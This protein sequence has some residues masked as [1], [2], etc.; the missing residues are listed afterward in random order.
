MCDCIS[1]LENRG[2]R[3]FPTFRY[4]GDAELVNELKAKYDTEFANKS[5]KL[6]NKVSILNSTRSITVNDV[7]LLLFEFL[8]GIKGGLLSCTFAKQA[9]RIVHANHPDSVLPISFLLPA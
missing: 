2:L 1:F 4:V 6:F 5:S 3:H 7:G 8:K 9:A